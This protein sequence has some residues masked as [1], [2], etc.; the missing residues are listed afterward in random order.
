MTDGFPFRGIFCNYDV[1]AK[2]QL[3]GV[4]SRVSVLHHF[5]LITGTESDENV[6]S[7]KYV[8]ENLN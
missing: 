7:H 3:V 4:L 5:T 6:V 8:A 1:V 2:L